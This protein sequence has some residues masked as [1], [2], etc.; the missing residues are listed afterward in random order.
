MSGLIDGS[1]APEETNAIWFLQPTVDCVRYLGEEL[2]FS[3]LVKRSLTNQTGMH[4]LMK[5]V[6]EWTAVPDDLKQG[7]A[8]L[9][10]HNED[11]APWA[12]EEVQS[13]Y[14]TVHAHSVVN[15]WN[16][17]YSSVHETFS[18]LLLRDT[19]SRSAAK[20][21]LEKSWKAKS[22]EFQ[23]ADAKEVGQ[24]LIGRLLRTDGA[25][26]ALAK[27]FELLGVPI[28]PGE[29]KFLRLEEV[30]C[31]RNCIVH[32]GGR[33][34]SYTAARVSSLPWATGDAITINDALASE[35]SEAICEFLS[36]IQDSL[37]QSRFS[38]LHGTKK[39]PSGQS[40]SHTQ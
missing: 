7:L 31:V 20:H 16:A 3:G 22:D 11:F 1:S 13:G 40:S 30:R 28:E 14:K 2:K 6:R 23:F 39:S 4:L 26:V 15:M 5:I 37:I 9:E 32:N 27:G 36:C 24:K 33:I 21:F 8:I 18:I 34:D 35:Y 25:H 12:V 19:T 38:P 29:R 17:L 10:A